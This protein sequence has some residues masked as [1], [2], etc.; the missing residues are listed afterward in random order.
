[1]GQALDPNTVRRLE[2]LA[3]LAGTSDRATKDHP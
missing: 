1:M 2:A 3:A